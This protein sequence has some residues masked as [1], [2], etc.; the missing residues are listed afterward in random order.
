IVGLSVQDLTT[1][2]M[3]ENSSTL[4]KYNLTNAYSVLC[5]F[6]KSTVFLDYTVTSADYDRYNQHQSIPDNG[7]SIYYK[8]NG[9]AIPQLCSYTKQTGACFELNLTQLDSIIFFVCLFV[10]YVSKKKKKKEK[11]KKKVTLKIFQMAFLWLVILSIIPLGFA[12]YGRG[13][14]FGCKLTCL[15]VC[16]F[17][18]LVL[19][20]AKFATFFFFLVGYSNILFCKKNICKVPQKIQFKNS[21]FFFFT[22]YMS[23]KKKKDSS[24]NL[25]ISCGVFAFVGGLIA[26]MAIL[27][28]CMGGRDI[29]LVALCV[30]EFCK[31]DFAGSYYCWWIGGDGNGGGNHHDNGCN[32][33]C[34]CHGCDCGHCGNCDGGGCGVQKNHSGM[35]LNATITIIQNKSLFVLLVLIKTKLLKHNSLKNFSL[36]LKQIFFKFIF[37]KE[38]C[39]V[40]NIQ[41][42]ETL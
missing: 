30:R 38:N 19:F 11:G 24:V 4:I 6:T 29:D 16:S 34:S 36:G 8:T 18:K 41:C 2:T 12:C 13:C 32:C 10:L 21:V 7:Q 22:F 26:L 40:L 37:L 14:C 31:D 28:Y 3:T 42:F 20:V 23:A 1:V 35:K 39:N 33:D 17:K 27:A 25:L 5:S 9:N 15:F